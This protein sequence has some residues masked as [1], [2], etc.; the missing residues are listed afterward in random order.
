MC[1]YF[2]L[3]LCQTEILPFFAYTVYVKFYSVFTGKGVRG[4]GGLG[5]TLKNHIYS[6]K[7]FV[8]HQV[9]CVIPIIHILDMVD[10]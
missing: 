1:K 2:N 6:L 4:R 7:R 10:W 3:H 8:V 9:L 5:D